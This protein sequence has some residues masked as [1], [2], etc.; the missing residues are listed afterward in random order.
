MMFLSND[1]G[2]SAILKLYDKMKISTW[3]Q[4]M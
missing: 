1:F 3:E 4:L 2:A